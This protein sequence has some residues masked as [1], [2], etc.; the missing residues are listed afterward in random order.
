MWIFDGCV[1]HAALLCFLIADVGNV[2]HIAAT[3]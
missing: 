2:L 3:A 1:L